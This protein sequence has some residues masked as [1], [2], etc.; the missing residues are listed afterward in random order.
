M[1]NDKQ[2]GGWFLFFCRTF[3]TVE[4]TLEGDPSGSSQPPVGI[5]TKDSF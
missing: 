2:I 4:T 1:A 5:K 3:K